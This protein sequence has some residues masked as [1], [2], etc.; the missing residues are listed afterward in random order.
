MTADAAPPQ[1]SPDGYWWWT[2]TEWVPAADLFAATVPAQQQAE[3]TPTHLDVQQPE[4]QYAPAE[5][6]VAHVPV[7]QSWQPPAQTQTVIPAQIEPV[8]QLPVFEILPPY[9]AAPAK[10]PNRLLGAIAGTVAAV[11]LI[12]GGAAY[13]ITHYLGGGG[14]QPEEVL[15]ANAV[16]VMKLDLDPSLSQKAALYRFSRSFPDLHVQQKTLK[17]DLL[18]PLFSGAGLN[19]DSDVKPWLGDRA[20]VAAV[21]KLTGFGFAPVAAVQYTD[22]DKAKRV[23]LGASM[24]AATGANPFFFAFS[25]DYAIIADTQGDADRYAAASTHLTD[26]ASYQKAVASLDGDQLAVGWADAKGVVQGL[27]SAQLAT[28]PMWNK[29][30]AKQMGSFVVGLHAASNYLEMQGKAVGLSN[31]ASQ[32]LGRA[33]TANLLATFPNDT[34]FAMEGT[35][36]GAGIA[37]AFEALPAVVTAQL[38]QNGLDA[39]D[40]TAILGTDAAVAMSG[41][42][43]SPNVF[44]HVRTPTPE[45]AVA[46]LHR[47]FDG[48]GDETP[49]SG[50][51]TI[52]QEK[53]GYLLTSN[54]TG[55]AGGQLGNTASFKRAVPDA[56]NAGVVLYVNL[57]QLPQE[58]MRGAQNLDAIGMSVNGATG[59][60]RLRVTTR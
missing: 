58:A 34:L 48:L 1:L 57:G 29:L 47:A 22:K 8:M 56:R 4:Q 38:Q 37:Q 15:P 19:Y 49:L 13:G 31:D 44:A 16:A 52:T 24:R 6:Y 33:K 54:P 45:L 32:Q 7:Q 3:P 39:A 21:P 53:T 50:P 23:L 30:K 10:K 36:L 40:L 27:T 59:E 11:L 35:G 51:L 28:S 20:A 25:G 14:Q 46:A 9:A 42:F 18:R 17:D 12:S 5:T 43:D 26:N 2:G 41:D 55:S 60:F